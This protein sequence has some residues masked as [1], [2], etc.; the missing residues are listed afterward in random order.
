[1]PVSNLVNENF[2]HQ[3]QSQGGWTPNPSSFQF[4]KIPSPKTEVGGAKLLMGPQSFV[5]SPGCTFGPNTHVS[6][7]GVIPPNT[8][9]VMEMGQPCLNMDAEG[10]C[11][12]SFMPPPPA[13]VP[14]PCTCKVKIQ[15]AGQDKVQGE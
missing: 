5:V 13:T 14:I 7:A 9:K 10:T 8:K 15:D 1:M 12:G 2:K 6:G 4:I 11:I 3:V